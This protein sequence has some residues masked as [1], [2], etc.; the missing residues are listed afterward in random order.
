MIYVAGNEYKIGHYPDNTLLL[1][2]PNPIGTRITW[3]Y[4]NSEEMVALMFLTKAI[5]EKGLMVSLEMPYIPNAR[6]D[7]VKDYYDI[8]SLKY[9]CEFINSLGFC[10]VSVLDPHSIVS[11][12]LI[13]N[14]FVNKNALK[15]Y[16]NRA[17][18]ASGA[19]VV[20]FPDE[21]SAKRYSD[22][23]DLP[24][25]FANKKRDWKTGKILGLELCKN[26]MDTTLWDGKVLIVDDICSKGGTFL[27]GAK[28]LKEIGAT[29]I[30]LYVTHCENSIHDGELINSGLLRKIYT[31][32]S[33]LTK[34]HE[35]I[36]VLV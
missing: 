22:M 5:K 33:I 29:E 13:N 7:R 1:K 35:L 26:G 25:F 17:V 2:V 11:E 9:F 21:G 4:E 34:P 8:F 14:L 32:P 24:Y 18:F 10:Q 31:T 16:I 20:F 27:F 36:E 28:A 3:L 15:S 6:M 12:A 19:S 23:I 30:S